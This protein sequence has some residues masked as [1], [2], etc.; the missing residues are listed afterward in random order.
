MES[1][2]T[3]FTQELEPDTNNLFNKS[4]YNCYSLKKIA[5]NQKIYEHGR[6]SDSVFYVETGRVILGSESKDGRTA[7]K[8]IIYPG[9]TFGE[10][11]VLGEH[12]RTG[13]AKALDGNVAVREIPKE[14]YLQ[15]LLNNTG[16]K[17]KFFLQ[18]GYKMR[19]INR[20][21]EDLLM[22]DARG[23]LINYLVHTAE[24]KGQKVGFEMMIKDP[25]KHKDLAN[26]TGTS[27][28]TTTT[29]LNELKQMNLIHIDRRRI[30]IRDID[31]L[32]DMAKI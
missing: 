13:F 12:T 23:R 4:F 15:I 25:L 32:K 20:K 24:E 30:L 17:S 2:T 27:R 14:D 3:T 1:L 16:M 10:M 21:I 29:I 8:E 31:I 7:I 22:R 28:Q 26:L 18:M 5:K 9:E 19:K 6:S 11:A